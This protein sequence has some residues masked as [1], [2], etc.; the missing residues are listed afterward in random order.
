MVEAVSIAAEVPEATKSFE[1][2]YSGVKVVAALTVLVLDVCC[3]E[4]GLF[5]NDKMLESSSVE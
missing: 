3:D 5:S 1:G 4:L 2:R